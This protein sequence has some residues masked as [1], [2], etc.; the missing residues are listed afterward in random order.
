[1]RVAASQALVRLGV[2]SG[3][4]G[5]LQ[6]LEDKSVETRVRIQ[7]VQ[8]LSEIA[9]PSLSDPLKQIVEEEPEGEVK[10]AM[11]YLVNRLSAQP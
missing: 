7:A 4:K 11:T 9:D 8:A 6:V 5:I 10:Q 2:T 1:M 3:Q